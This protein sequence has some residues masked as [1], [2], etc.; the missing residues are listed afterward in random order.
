MPPKFKFTREE[1]I[2]AALTIVRQAG[3]AALT[4]RSLADALQA[5]A[6]PI[7]SFFGSM[8]EVE[9]AVVKKTVDLLHR[10]MLRKETG[11]PWHDHGIGYVLFAMQEKAL[12]RAVNDEKHIPLFKA[13][14]NIIWETL[15]TALADYPPFAGL[16]AEQV[17]RIQL[18]RW[19]FAHGMA[20]SV[21][22]PPPDT[23]T[24]AKIVAAMQEGSQAIYHGLRQQFQSPPQ[25]EGG[26]HGSTRSP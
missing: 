15:T 12:F 9:E 18:H 8:A 23:W 7:Y 24:K 19:L 5:S 2:E 14:G 4:T 11:D 3:W 6:R 26:D 20:F 10:R 21:S 16:S 13:Y 22:A 25:P 1:I 17:G